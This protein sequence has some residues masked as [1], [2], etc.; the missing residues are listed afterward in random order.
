MEVMPH[1]SDCKEIIRTPNNH[2][3]VDVESFRNFSCSS[4]RISFDGCSQVV[5]VNFRWPV[6]MLLIFKP[7]VSF[8]KLLEPP[9]HCTFIGSS[10]A[11]CIADVASRLLCL[12][13]HFK[14]E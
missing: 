6:T 14:L 5:I 4:K 10:W 3:M 11:R 1:D 7:L 13:T 2:S 9:L 12:T 8:A